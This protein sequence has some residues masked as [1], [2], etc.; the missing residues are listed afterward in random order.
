MPA[1]VDYKLLEHCSTSIKILKL[2]GLFIHRSFKKGAKLFKNKVSVEETVERIEDKQN[3]EDWKGFL[4][5]N[6]Y[7]ENTKISFLHLFYCLIFIAI[8]IVCFPILSLYEL[9]SERISRD[10]VNISSAYIIR[11]PLFNFSDSP[12]VNALLQISFSLVFILSITVPLY[13]LI[14]NFAESGFY[15]SVLFYEYFERRLYKFINDYPIGIPLKT[16]EIL[17]VHS[18]AELLKKFKILYIL[19]L[20]A[21]TISSC[22]VSSTNKELFNASGFTKNLETKIIFIFHIH[23]LFCALW[24]K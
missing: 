9:F 19:C 20:L 23:H 7:L 13:F 17:L 21:I 6:N 15:K 3:E 24:I 8:K 22:L 4:T 10:N 16:R 2:Q 11:N 1:Y 14:I 5:N 18:N 12:F